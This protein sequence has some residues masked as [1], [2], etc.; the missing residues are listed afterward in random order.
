MK[1]ATETASSI[2]QC[3]IS[4]PF[5]LIGLAD[6]QRFDIFPIEGSRPFLSMRSIGGEAISFVVMEPQGVIADY[7]IELNEEDSDALRISSAEDALVLNIVTIHTSR[8]LFV[9]VNLAGP[10]IVNR[11]TMI[12]KQLIIGRSSKYP[13]RHVLIDERSTS[14]ANTPLQPC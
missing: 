2:E 4:L 12:G 8:P 3:Q 1:L 6:L 13:V 10:V 5:G 7:A 11:Q 9:T 14:P